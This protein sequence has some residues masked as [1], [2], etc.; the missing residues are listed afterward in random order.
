MTIDCRRGDRRKNGWSPRRLLLSDR[1][2]GNIGGS[3]MT[4]E[5]QATTDPLVGLECTVCGQD[6]HWHDLAKHAAAEDLRR[7]RAARRSIPVRY[8]VR[9]MATWPHVSLG[10]SAHVWPL[11]FAHLSLHLP[12][13]VLIVG[14]RGSA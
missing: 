1:S 3:V 10:I 5:K 2:V 14:Y 9:F 4:D 13:G 8:G 11:K 7:L 12:V 6:P